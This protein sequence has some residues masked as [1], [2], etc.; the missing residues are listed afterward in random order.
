VA[1]VGRGKDR[2]DVH[3]G[4]EPVGIRLNEIF[5]ENVP[6]GALVDVLRPVLERYAARRSPGQ[7][8]GDWCHVVGVTALRHELGTEQWVR[9]P[10]LAATHAT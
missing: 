5:C 6:R 4:G 10:G 2:Y 9:T 7:R 3:L 1:F 8:F